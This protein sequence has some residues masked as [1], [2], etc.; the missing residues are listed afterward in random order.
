MIRLAQS[1][2]LP[3]MVTIYNEAVVHQLTADTK[4]ITLEQREDWLE[5]HPEHHYPVFVFEQQSTVIGWLSLSAWRPGRQALFGVAEVSYYVTREQQSK[6]IATQLMRYAI[7]QAPLLGLQHF[8][9]ILL[10]DNGR[11]IHLLQK[12]GF[13]QW[14]HFPGVAQFGRTRKDQIIYGLAL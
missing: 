14:G 7:E 5:Q 3:K 10:A 1:T 6:G 4:P 13:T 12:F 11:S 8:I 2:D 9:A